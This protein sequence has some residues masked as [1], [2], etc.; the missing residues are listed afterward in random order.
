MWKEVSAVTDALMQTNKYLKMFREPINSGPI[1][2][3]LPHPG[4][5]LIV[6]EGESKHTHEVDL[7]EENYR[8]LVEKG[9]PVKV[10]SS[11]NRNHFHDLLLRYNKDHYYFYIEQ[12]DG[13]YRRW[14]YRCSEGHFAKLIMDE[15]GSD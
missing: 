14:P 10:V 6:Q 12:C 8:D 5:A 15:K 11:T 1:P 9:M 3:P 2:T 7:S 4:R 13:A